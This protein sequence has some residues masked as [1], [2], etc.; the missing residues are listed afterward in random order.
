M[1]ESVVLSGSIV[2][3]CSLIKKIDLDA[4]NLLASGC[5][6]RL[7]A[8]S[9]QEINRHHNFFYA[10]EG[11]VP[12]SVTNMQNRF[13]DIAGLLASCMEMIA[14]VRRNN[15]ALENVHLSKDHIFISSTGYKFIYMPIMHKSNLDAKHFLHKV[16]ALLQ[17]KDLRVI[18]LSKELRKQNDEA[19]VID[20]MKNYLDDF[21]TSSN[22]DVASESA[23]AEE[24]TT[25]LNQ[26]YVQEPLEIYETEVKIPLLSDDGE[27]TI[28]SQEMSQQVTFDFAEGE[29]TLL[30]S[31]DSFDQSGERFDHADEENGSDPPSGRITEYYQD[32]YAE[33]ETTVLTSQPP[34]ADPVFAVNDD[35]H[36]TLYLIRNSTGEKIPIDS[37]IFTIG[38]DCNSMDYV[39]DNESVS[40]HH[41]TVIYENGGYY[42]MDNRSTNG[43]M[44]EGIRLQP[45]EKAELGNGY[46]V[47]MGNESFQAVLERR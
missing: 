15:L 42:I 13:E 32:V 30:S 3:T 37:A 41:A 17:S 38:K 2:C 19:A 27:T 35:N 46:I 14:E 26:E 22:P 4:L 10:L 29:T 25:L 39:L 20:Y 45:F 5:C 11:A 43:T 21:L 18:K 24:E 47:S 44:I 6:E 36:Y 23:F 28:L 9:Y 8:C 1:T 12:I 40:R 33:C 34:L 31:E 16:I 7:C